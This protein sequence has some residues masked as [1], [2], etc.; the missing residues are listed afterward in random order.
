MAQ[1]Q[2]DT[3]ARGLPGANGHRDLT[4]LS[5]P[6]EYVYALKQWRQVQFDPGISGA[7]GDLTIC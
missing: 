1:R 5:G 2:C 6:T 7:Y 4:G 3:G